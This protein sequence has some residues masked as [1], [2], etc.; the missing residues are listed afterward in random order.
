MVP[1]LLVCQ[2]RHHFH[3]MIFQDYLNLRVIRGFGAIEGKWKEMGVVGYEGGVVT[4]ESKCGFLDC[5]GD[6]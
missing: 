6:G 4:F 5:S 2:N 1:V 3:Q